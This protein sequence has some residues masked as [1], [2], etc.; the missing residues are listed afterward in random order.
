MTRLLSFAAALVLAVVVPVAVA[1]PKPKPKPKPPAPAPAPAPTPT[2]TPAPAPS[3]G[4]LVFSDEFNGTQVDSSKWGVYDGPGHNGN[5]VRR[6]SQVTVQ[7]GNLVITAEQ[8][9]GKLTSG[10]MQM[11]TGLLYGR[12]EFR[13]R[14]DADPSASTSAIVMTWPSVEYWPQGGEN[15]IFETLNDP[16]RTPVHSYVHYG[17]D[18]RQYSFDHPVDGKQWHTYAMDWS[19]LSITISIDGVVRGVVI[20]PAA[21]PHGPHAIAIQLD[22][23]AQ[24]MTGKTSM[25]VDW[26]RW[27]Q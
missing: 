22:G 14:A 13:A 9:Q 25:Q 2:P 12:F 16:D 1:A 23:Q 11:W 4:K 24:K 18:N 6:P 3:V 5:G 27:Y 26:V 15:D 8:K 19:P 10:G 20:D 7:G 21:I 17:I